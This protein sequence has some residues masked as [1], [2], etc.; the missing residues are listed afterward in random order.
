MGSSFEYAWIHERNGGNTNDS[1][2]LLYGVTGSDADL[3]DWAAIMDSD[4]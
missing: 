4:N 2:E 3:R 1:S